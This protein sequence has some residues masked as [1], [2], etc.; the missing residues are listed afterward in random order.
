MDTAYNVILDIIEDFEEFIGKLERRRVELE[1]L[2][3]E[4]DR[5]YK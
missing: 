5:A 3:D 2:K 4:F 1:E